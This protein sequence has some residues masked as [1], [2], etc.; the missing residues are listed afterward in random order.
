[1][2]ESKRLLSLLSGLS[3]SIQ[4]YKSLSCF[5]LKSA[6]ILDSILFDSFGIFMQ[7][8]CLQNIFVLCSVVYL[9]KKNI[10]FHLRQTRMKSFNISTSVFYISATPFP[11]VLH[12]ESEFPNRDADVESRLVDTVGEGVKRSRSVVSDSA[13]P[14]TVAYQAPPSMGFSRQEYWNGLP[15]PSPGDFPALGG[16]FLSQGSNPGL[17]HCRQTLQP[18]SHQESGAN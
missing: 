6:S 8:E 1:M 17:P 10:H 16:M 9:E 12:K 3:P 15:F 7:Y 5:L 18:L 2:E 11:N 14:Q 4:T 13:T